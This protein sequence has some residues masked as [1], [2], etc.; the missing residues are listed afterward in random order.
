MAKFRSG[1]VS[2]S[3]SSSFIVYGTTLS[4][5]EICQLVTKHVP[6]SEAIKEYGSWEKF[7]EEL[8]GDTAWTLD[9][10]TFP[11]EAYYV[12][13]E[14]TYYGL[15]ADPESLSSKQVK[16]GLWSKAEFA[17]VDDLLKEVGKEANVHTG[18][19]YG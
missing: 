19:T 10:V 6:E 3:S 14:G 15:Y 18:T 12:E 1:F 11:L 17:E 16:D 8:D 5:E 2:N 13:D 4:H 9:H 7:I